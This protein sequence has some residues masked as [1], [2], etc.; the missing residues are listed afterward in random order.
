MAHATDLDQIPKKNGVPRTVLSSTPFITHSIP[1][2]PSTSQIIG[3]CTISLDRAG[4]DQHGWYI[5]DFLAFKSMLNPSITRRPDNQV[6]YG[7]PKNA[8]ASLSAPY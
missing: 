8:I 3:L 7:L 2:F 5:E 6:S 1:K 4:H